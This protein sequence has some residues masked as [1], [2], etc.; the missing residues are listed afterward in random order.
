MRGCQ[1]SINISSFINH[2]QFLILFHCFLT[3][4]LL[5]THDVVAREVYGDEALRVTPPPITPYLNGGDEVD[6]VTDNGDLQHV[7]R[8]RLVQFQKN[9]DEPMGITLKMTEDGRCIVARIMHGGMIHRQATL[10]VGDEIREINGQPVQNQTVSQLQRL[11]VSSIVF[12]H[13]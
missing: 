3:Q 7:T 5:H 13:L 4:A 1:E 6:N 12:K 9:T 10:H 11:L 8:V 2:N